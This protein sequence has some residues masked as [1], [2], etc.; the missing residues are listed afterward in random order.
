MKKLQDL[1][2]IIRSSKSFDYKTKITESLDVFEDEKGDVTIT[3]PLRYLGNFW[4]SLDIPLI[5]CEV[6]LILSWYKECVLVG[7]DFR[8]PPAAAANHINSPTDAKFEITD[9]K[10]YVPVV[11]FIINY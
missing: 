4:R 5:N 11:T 2:L 7:R 3:I 8:G 6:T 9:C 1:C 10:L